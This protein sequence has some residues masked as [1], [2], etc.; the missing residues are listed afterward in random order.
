[1]AGKNVVRCRR[2]GPG[3]YHTPF[4]VP[5]SVP[6]RWDSG[7]PEALFS[8]KILHKTEA[9]NDCNQCRNICE[10]ETPPEEAN[11]T[12]CAACADICPVRAIGFGWKQGRVSR[13]EKEVK[14]GVGV[15][16]G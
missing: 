14:A 9:C 2:V 15:R 10:L 5:L 11:C 6:D 8:P 13:I 16:S 7:S 1:M 3:D 12:N 4:L